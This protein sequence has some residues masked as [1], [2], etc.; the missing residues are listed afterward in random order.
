MSESLQG[1][2]ETASLIDP[3]IMIFQRHV[4][5]VYDVKVVRLVCLASLSIL[6]QL[7]G[8]IVIFFYSLFLL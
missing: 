4:Q 7:L 3:L 2:L 8:F 1:C 6:A 5:Y